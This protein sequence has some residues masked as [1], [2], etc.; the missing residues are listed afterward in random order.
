MKSLQKSI[1]FLPFLQIPSGHH[2]VVDALIDEIS[3]H[4]PAVTCEKIDILSYSFGKI[5]KIISKVY[6]NWIQVF[7][8]LYNLVYR[9]SVYKHL[10][11][12]KRFWLYECL[13][14]YF[15]R[16]LLKEK[17][18]DLIICTHALPSYMVNCLKKRKQVQIPVINIYTD[19]FIHCF[20]GIENI[21][22]HFVA[23]TPMKNYLNQK[24]IGNENIFITGIPI[25]RKIRKQ[26]QTPEQKSIASVLIAGGNLGVGGMEK[27][28]QQILKS[29]QTQGIRFYVLC[30]KNRNL[31]NKLSHLGHP[32][33][34]PL[35]Y[36]E[37][38]E[39]LNA[40]YDHIDAILTKPGGV[41]ISESLFKRKPIFIYDALPGQE[42]IN[43]CELQDLGVVFVLDKKRALEQFLQMFQNQA[44][45]RKY[46]SQID[47]FHSHLSAKKPLDV[48]T[49]ILIRETT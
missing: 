22:F 21:D 44:D 37:C 39:K 41:T 9:N 30:G 28:I 49:D 6:L 17:K 27:V 36:L 3:E 35:P 45:M 46:Y 42:E 14:I 38:K 20:W 18:P 40:L 8:N 31:Y 48:I 16:K 1:L 33:I 25:H 19:Y 23:S 26:T 2:Q 32:S 12:N 24:G 15:M 5:E 29:E 34:I 11:D 4:Y 10:E 13:F 47:A 43:R 7:P